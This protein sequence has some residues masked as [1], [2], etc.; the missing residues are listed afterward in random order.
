MKISKEH[1]GGLPEETVNKIIGL[2]AVLA[3]QA[4]VILYGSRAKNSYRLQS[5]ID[6][7]LDAGAP[8]PLAVLGEVHDVLESTNIAQKFDIVDMQTIKGEFKNEVMQYGIVWKS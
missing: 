7:A 3:P 6:I 4:K 8:L 1:L 2:I 5:D